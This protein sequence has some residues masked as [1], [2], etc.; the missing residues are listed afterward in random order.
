MT[1][2]IFAAACLCIQC[3]LAQVQV[4]G[5]FKEIVARSDKAGSIKR[6]KVYSLPRLDNL[7][8]LQDAEFAES[9]AWDESPQLKGYRFAESIPF[10]LN[11]C[12]SGDWEENRQ[13]GYRVLR[14]TISSKDAKSLSLTF[15]D[16]YLPKNGEL[17]I[18]GQDRVLG[19]FVGDVN[20]KPNGNFATMP[21][22]GDVLQIE[23]YEPLE[24]AKNIDSADEVV[25]ILK[26]MEE[27][28]LRLSVSN[29]AHGFRPIF[30]N[31]GTA[32]SCNVDVVCE[33]WAGVLL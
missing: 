27:D 5:H 13:Q 28:G 16:F 7:K 21:L 33:K 14:A 29:V 24:N 1:L 20:N 26:C 6:S 18:I 3:I 31:F 17:Y 32:G 30:N 8:L 12:K 15:N 22:P 19:A 25:P 23:Y 9:S 10:S 4:D 2:L 11:I